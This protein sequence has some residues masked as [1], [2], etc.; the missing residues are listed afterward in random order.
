[1]AAF[2][3]LYVRGGL[4]DS[5]ITP[6]RLAR[7]LKD[8]LIIELLFSVAITFL[9]VAIG[10]QLWALVKLQD[11]SSQRKLYSDIQRSVIIFIVGI[12]VIYDIPWFF[13]LLFT[14]SPVDFFWNRALGATN[15]TCLSNEVQAGISYTQASL[16]F[17]S[18]FALS[19]MPIWILW[20]VK[21]PFRLK[22]TVAGLL[23]AGI[24]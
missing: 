9:R 1:M 11:L 24:G 21:M 7:A 4:V 5:Q 10:L 23:A 2:C 14:C 20:S 18:D 22:A 16:S 19:L 6:E 15:G 13:T 12:I 8:Q 17:V 3:L